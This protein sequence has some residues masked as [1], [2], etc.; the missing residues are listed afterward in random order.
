MCNIFPWGIPS[1]SLAHTTVAALPPPP[2]PRHPQRVD[3]TDHENMSP[4]SSARM[5]V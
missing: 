3:L 4:T 5:A 2:L 1:I